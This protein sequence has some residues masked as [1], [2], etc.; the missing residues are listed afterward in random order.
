MGVKWIPELLLTV[1]SLS[2]LTMEI[3]YYDDPDDSLLDIICSTAGFRTLEFLSLTRITTCRQTLIRLLG[4]CHKLRHIDL[5]RIRLEPLCFW[6]D[7]LPETISL[8]PAL[9][10][11]SVMRLMNESHEGDLGSPTLFS[12]LG[13]E[14]VL[15]GTETL[16][17]ELSTGHYARKPK[18]MTAVLG[19]RYEGKE[20]E[21]CLALIAR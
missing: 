11:F 8:L 12:G 9:T 18:G 21:K 5:H 19:V 4:H 16:G 2:S 15:P 1:V 6:P 7:V 13:G 10:V 3:S 20:M 17:F 14:L